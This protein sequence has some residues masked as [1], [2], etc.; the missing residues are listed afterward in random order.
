[1]T[2]R[3][4]DQR[5]LVKVGA[6]VTGLTVILMIMVISIGKE[7][8]LFSSK[9]DIRARV[10]NVSNLKT[11]SFV[12]LKGIR[13]GAVTD[14]RIISDEEVEILMTVLEDSLQWM[15]EDSR[16][17]ISTAGLVGDKFVEVL[18]G[19]KSAAPFNPEK[20]VLMSEEVLDFKNIMSKGESITDVTDRILQKLD[21]VLT[22]IDDG[23]LLVS[24]LQSL[25]RSAENLEKITNEIKEAKLSTM[26]SN[27]NSAADSMERIITRV[28]KGPGTLNSLIYDEAVHDDLRALL[29]GAQRNKVIKYFIR[30]SIKQSEERDKIRN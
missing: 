13:I 3:K 7:T 29:G 18:S 27:V 14:I 4:K 22:K 26:I 25:G 23:A 20:D 17:S 8:S 16:V 9:V 19:S 6:F 12:E 5:N 28:E 2:I 11:G 15:K 10:P 21:R 24:S 1:M 30:E